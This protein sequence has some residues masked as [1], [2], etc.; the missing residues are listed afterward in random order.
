MS[1]HATYREEPGEFVSR[2]VHHWPRMESSFKLILLAAILLP[3]GYYLIANGLPETPSD[4]ARIIVSWTPTIAGAAVLI[5]G[6]IGIFTATRSLSRKQADAIDLK[7]RAS[8]VTLRG[9]RKI[10]WEQIES[11][12]AITCVNN[13][14][15][16]LLWDRAELHRRLVLHLREK[17]Q[18]LNTQGSGRTESARV[19]L[20]RYPAA[21][22][23]RLYDSTL[24]QFKRRGIPVQFEK[25]WMFT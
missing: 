1:N 19:D 8:G 12:T 15:I 23:L 6:C 24:E 13:S 2:G 25:K 7:L 21:E 3:L 10:P 22:Y 4:R 14:K 18:Q 20:L 11:V 5:A 9:G 16:R 17:S